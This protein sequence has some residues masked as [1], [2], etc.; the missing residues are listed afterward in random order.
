MSAR[1][2]ILDRLK[3]ALSRPDLPFPAVDPPRLLRGHHRKV[4]ELVGDQ[5]TLAARFGEELT[6]VGGSYEIAMS[7]AA[8]RLM[9]VSRII[10]WIEE[11]AN[12]RKGMVLQTGQ[13][14]SILCWDPE[15]LGI[16][17]I[18]EALETMSLKI[19][20]PD[21]LLTDESRNAVRH[22]PY[23]LTG[24]TAACASTG[25]MIMAS[26]VP[27]TS[28]SASLL[29]TRHMAVIPF[30]RLYANFEEWVSEQRAA[31]TLI[32]TMRQNANISLITGPSKSADIE[33]ALTLG[34]HGPKFVHAL[35]FDDTA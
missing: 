24:V 14:R 18:G 19:V 21:E 22:I 26:S 27:G 33:G 11:D 25:T 13:D 3:S 28:R 8:A 9:C 16:D 20:S 31:D 17:G 5:P 30:S 4:T 12:S 7:M 2:D 23:G 1:D 29:P 35:L 15:I 34:V 10:T 32:D 6:K